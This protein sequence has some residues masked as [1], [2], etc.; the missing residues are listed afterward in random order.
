MSS[1]KHDFPDGLDE[2]SC[3]SGLG[4]KLAYLRLIILALILVVAMM[5]FAGG[6]G[7]LQTGV[8]TPTAD[9]RLD[10]PQRLRNGNFFE[11][12]MTVSAHRPIDNVILAIPASW[13]RKITINSLVPTPI[14]EEMD[15]QELRYHFGPLKAGETL[16]FKVD[17]QVNPTRIGSGSGALRLFDGEREIAA[18]DTKLEVIF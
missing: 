17:G 14:D 15:G 18:L 8:S 13:W 4:S 12:T 3:D 2:H 9:F 1:L 10:G 11:T 7:D 6:S 16:Q 5:G